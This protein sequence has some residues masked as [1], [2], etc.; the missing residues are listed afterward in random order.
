MVVCRRR[1]Y[2]QKL[3]LAPWGSPGTHDEKRMIARAHTP[4]STI[5]AEQGALTPFREGTPL[6]GAIYDADDRKPLR[7]WRVRLIC[8]DKKLRLSSSCDDGTHKRADEG[9]EIGY[10]ER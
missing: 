5:I 4:R 3:K 9:R 2:V 8:G 1:S 10:E 7:R 6:G